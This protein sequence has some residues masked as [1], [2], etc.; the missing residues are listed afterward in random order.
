MLICNAANSLAF[1]SSIMN[2][3]GN[4][5]DLRIFELKKPMDI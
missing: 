2:I 5:I 3:N 4:A 1:G